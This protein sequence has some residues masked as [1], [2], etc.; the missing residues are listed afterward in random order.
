VGS[1]VIA[2]D[3]G[4]VDDPL[5]KISQIFESA[6]VKVSSKDPAKVSELALAIGWKKLINTDRILFPKV[7]MM[8]VG[9]R[10]LVDIRMHTMP[11]IPMLMHFGNGFLKRYLICEY[12]ELP[13]ANR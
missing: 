2:P 10:V 12:F 7:I 9:T 3:T 1:V 11:T 4:T 5:E 13:A 8:L 6:G